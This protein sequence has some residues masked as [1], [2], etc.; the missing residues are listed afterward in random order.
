MRLQQIN[1]IIKSHSEGNVSVSIRFHG[2]QSKN[3][4]DILLNTTPQGGAKRKVS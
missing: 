1:K 2:N 3:C 4:G